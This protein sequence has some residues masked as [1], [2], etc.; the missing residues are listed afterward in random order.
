MKTKFKTT[1][2]KKTDICS[3]KSRSWLGTGTKLWQG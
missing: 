3:W 1:T 2:Q